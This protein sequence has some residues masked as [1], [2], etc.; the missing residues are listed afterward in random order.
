MFL[1]FFL[2]V[3]LTSATAINIL[4]DH[5]AIVRF[6]S[7][8]CGLCERHKEIWDSAV[9][10]YKYNE[11]HHLYS[12]DCDEDLSTC[13]EFNVTHY[14]SFSVR[15]DALWSDASSFVTHTNLMNFLHNVDKSCIPSNG[16]NCI[17]DE[18]IDINEMEKKIAIMT[19][20][21]F[22]LNHNITSMFEYNMRKLQHARMLHNK[23]TL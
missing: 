14:P 9:D 12:V 13:D 11:T 21:F 19:M 2:L 4:P 16:D 6:S 23:D 5:T 20:N 18:T 1:V 17:I 3:S 7:S 10:M 22:K 8:T 15:V